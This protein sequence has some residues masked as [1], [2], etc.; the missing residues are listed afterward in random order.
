[1]QENQQNLKTSEQ[2]TVKPTEQAPNLTN[3]VAT[4]SSLS[5]ES[6]DT[7]SPIVVERP[8]SLPCFI[9]RSNSIYKPPESP[10]TTQ[11]WSKI[12]QSHIVNKVSNSSAESEADISPISRDRGH[13]ISVMSPARIDELA[14]LKSQQAKV[15]E[16]SKYSINPSF[17]FLQLYHSSFFGNV[18]EKPLL[19]PSSTSHIIERSVKVLSCIPPFE[20]HKVGIVYVGV[21]QCN[22][23]LEILKNRFGSVRYM[24][25]LK[26]LG[27][28]I[29]LENIDPQTCFLGGLECNGDHGKCFDNTFF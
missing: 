7:N 25:F 15:K 28:I 3:V 9:S 24:N 11:T 12:A 14:T 13:T 29:K 16:I 8:T 21:G 23:E 18:N 20:T 10:S 26:S 19:V 17:V 6:S 2:S 5:L 22:N 1:M 4:I 27:T